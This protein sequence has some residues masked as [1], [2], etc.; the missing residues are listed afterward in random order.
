[1][2]CVSG[3]LQ[4]DKTK[5]QIVTKRCSICAIHE[6]TRFLCNK[7][8]TVPDMT[9]VEALAKAPASAEKAAIQTAADDFVTA[10]DAAITAGKLDDDSGIQMRSEFVDYLEDLAINLS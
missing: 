2:K 10:L 3:I 9:T 1:M 6:T 4:G 7:G 8:T 5:L